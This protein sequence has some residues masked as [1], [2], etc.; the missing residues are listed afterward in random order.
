M[1]KLDPSKFVSS[2]ELFK[3]WMKNPKFVAEWKK[4]EPDYQIA[5]QMIGARIK[6]KMSRRASRKSKNSKVK[7]LIRLAKL[8]KLKKSSKKSKKKKKR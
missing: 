8:G 2:D 3:K 4:L 5:S 1:R 7:K 6:K